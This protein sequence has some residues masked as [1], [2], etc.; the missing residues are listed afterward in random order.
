[1]PQAAVFDF[2]GLLV[3]GL[4]E[5]VLVTW[6]GFHEKGADAFGPEGLEAVP[7]H[8]IETFRHHRSFSRHLG[9]FASA[10]YLPRRFG[11]QAAFDAAFATLETGLVEDFVV[12][13]SEYRNRVRHQ[14]YERWLQYH[15]FYPGVAL[16]LRNRVCPIYIV[17][18]KDAS[19][20]G[21]LL[22][23]GRIAVP[24]ERIFGECRDKIAALRQ[25]AETE[26]VKATEIR[27]FDDNV[28]NACDAHENGFTSYW[29]DWGYHAPD[30]PALA[31]A[32]GVTELSLH[33]FT[34]MDFGPG[35][36][37]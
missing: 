24:A 26:G 4:D 16:L 5:C 15:A 11:S 8:F 1:M 17:S 29:A 14:H 28:M 2:D 9:H 3:D 35:S 18:G 25:I 30:H 27:F 34:R 23:H 33:A 37:P 32:A 20:V 21:E 19:S 13:V 6:N 22:R 10:F 7:A 31:R 12:R 36:G